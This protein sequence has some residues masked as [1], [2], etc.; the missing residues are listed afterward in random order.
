MKSTIFWDITPYSPLSVT[1][2]SEEHIASI[3]RV[4]KIIWAR[5]QRESRWQAKP[6]TGFSFG[7]FFDPED[8]GDMFLRN[9]G[10]AQRTTRRYIPGDGTLQQ[11]KVSSN[12]VWSNIYFSLLLRTNEVTNDTPQLVYYFVAELAWN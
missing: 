12:G 3:F 8:K 1:D 2:V 4:V 11:R 5:N 7:L 10:D 9:V 6:E